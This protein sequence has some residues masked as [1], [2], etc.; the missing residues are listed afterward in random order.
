[1]NKIIFTDKASVVLSAIA[2][3]ISIGTAI[4]QISWSNDLEKT[5]HSVDACEQYYLS[6]SILEVTK[7]L[8][9]ESRGPYSDGPDGKRLE[10]LS[11]PSYALAD[12]QT[13]AGVEMRQKITTLVNFFNTIALGI[14][15]NLYHEDIMKGCYEG[16]FNCAVEG[17]INK[18]KIADE[19]EYEYLV[20]I[21]KKWMKPKEDDKNNEKACKAKAPVT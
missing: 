8:Y 4:A 1:M 21:Q 20:K 14:D 19:K 18:Y 9:I 11:G 17:F 5:A 12:Q 10:P 6:E 16:Y 3:I 15:R 7:Y 2:I 13:R